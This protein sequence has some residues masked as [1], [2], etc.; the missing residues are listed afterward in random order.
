M[1]LGNQVLG[2]KKKKKRWTCEK[3]K[4]IF[5]VAPGTEMRSP[6]TLVFCALKIACK[7]QTHDTQRV[8]CLLINTA[9]SVFRELR[10]A[11]WDP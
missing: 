4:D 8:M 1:I 11:K 5:S 2:K 7:K 3:E 6:G 9:I 10:S